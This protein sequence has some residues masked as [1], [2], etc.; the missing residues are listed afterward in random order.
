METH[1]LKLVSGL[2]TRIGIGIGG[3]SICGAGAGAQEA[4]SDGE[5]EDTCTDGAQ[6][7]AEDCEAEVC[8]HRLVL[9][10]MIGCLVKSSLLCLSVW[11]LNVRTV[12]YDYGWS[13]LRT[14]DRTSRWS[15][16]C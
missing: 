10:Y 11:Y 6:M 7:P 14:P 12:A 15:G 3:G 1:V 2:W 5:D 4:G 8:I 13:S 9:L 16:Q